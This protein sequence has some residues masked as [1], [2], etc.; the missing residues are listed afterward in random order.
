MNK[1]LNI[2]VFISYCFHVANVLN[3]VYLAFW[4]PNSQTATYVI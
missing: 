2:L 3:M 4:K 1:V